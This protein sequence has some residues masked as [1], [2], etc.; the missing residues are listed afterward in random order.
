MAS[1]GVPGS[2]K[3]FSE[4][5]KKWGTKKWAELLAP[6]VNLARN[7]FTVDQALASEMLGSASTLRNDPESNR[8]FL[9]DG[10]PYQA[11]E[12]FRQPELASTLERIATKGADDFYDGETARKLAAAMAAHGGLITEAD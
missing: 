4:A 6:A 10:K 9:R 8:I 11:G 5:Y 7:G 2:V 1:S 3:G 12:T